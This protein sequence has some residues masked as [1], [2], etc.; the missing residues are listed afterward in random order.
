MVSG[1]R[2]YVLEHIQ[3]LN[4]VLIDLER[5]SYTISGAKSQLY[6]VDI[7]VIGY[8]CDIEDR[9]PDTTKIIK[10]L[11]WLYYDSVIEVRVFLDI[12]I[13]FRIWI[14]DFTIITAPIYYLYRKNMIFEWGE[15]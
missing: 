8:L 6:M 7:R 15:K 9:H 5:A 2:K 3:W 11:E 13:Y 4:G 1:I 12:Y 14:P 10:I